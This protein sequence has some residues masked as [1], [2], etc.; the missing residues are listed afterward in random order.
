MAQGNAELR[1]NALRIARE[2]WEQQVEEEKNGSVKIEES[3][4]WEDYVLTKENEYSKI[5]ETLERNAHFPTIHCYTLLRRKCE[6]ELERNRF[7][8]AGITL[9]QSQAITFHHQA[10]QQ[11]SKRTFKLEE[12][13]KHAKITAKEPTLTLTDDEEDLFKNELSDEDEDSPSWLQK[14]ESFEQ[15]LSRILSFQSSEETSKKFSK[16]LK[17]LPSEWRIVQINAA[18]PTNPSNPFKSYAKDEG[19]INISYVTKLRTFRYSSITIPNNVNI[20]S[21]S[22]SR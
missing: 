9:L 1:R 19:K 14:G 13:L 15:M 10:L 21:F 18:F 5:C 2:Y 4:R 20:I 12:K 6:I 7:R 17:K 8:E 3:V 22:Q 16:L 11:Y